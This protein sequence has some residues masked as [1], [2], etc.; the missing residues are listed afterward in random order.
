ME[1]FVDM[2]RTLRRKKVKIE[3]KLIIVREYEEGNR[4]MKEIAERNNI[5]LA[6]YLDGL[7]TK[8]N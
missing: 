6:E 3:D 7:K 2:V 1:E 4:S 8:K 5:I